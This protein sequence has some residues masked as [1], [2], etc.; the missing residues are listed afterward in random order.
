MAAVLGSEGWIGEVGFAG[1]GKS[2]PGCRKGG[3]KTTGII[4]N[5]QMSMH[6]VKVK[7]RKSLGLKPRVN[8]HFWIDSDFESQIESQKKP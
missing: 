4:V 1:L 8:S 3:K 6:A 5:W 2:A 7:H